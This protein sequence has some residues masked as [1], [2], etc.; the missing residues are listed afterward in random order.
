[1]STKSTGES[2]MSTKATG[3]R[4]VARVP[5]PFDGERLQVKLDHPKRTGAVLS[6]C[7]QGRRFGKG[8]VWI[9]D[10]ERGCYGFLPVHRLLAL[11]DAVRE[12]D[13]ERQ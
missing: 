12:A 7:P 1:M 8:Y 13:A 10:E 11:A 9:G 2:R 6:V 5:A 3:I 4:K